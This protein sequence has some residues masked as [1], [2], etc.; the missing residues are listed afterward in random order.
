MSKKVKAQKVTPSQ[1]HEHA[2]YALM[3]LSEA[4]F[5]LKAIGRLCKKCATDTG[6]KNAL[7]SNAIILYGSVFKYSNIGDGKKTKVEESIVPK[8]YMELHKRLIDYRDQFVAHFDFDY[9]KPTLRKSKKG[10]FYKLTD[11]PKPDIKDE[12]PEIEQL[13]LEVFTILGTWTFPAKISN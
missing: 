3:R 4:Y 9:S 8:E 7:L 6:V 10:N 1:E 11:V 2:V 12:L 13:I 5:T